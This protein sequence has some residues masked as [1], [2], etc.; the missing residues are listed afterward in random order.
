MK[1]LWSPWRMKFVQSQEANANC[2]FCRVQA[3]TNDL[4]NLIVF[5]GPRAF[6]ILNRYPYTSGHLLV[7][8]NSHQPSIE[9]LDIEIRSEMMELATVCMRVIRK[10]YQPEAFNLGANIGEAAGAGIAGHVH[11]HVVPRWGGDTNFMSALA[12]TRVLPEELS[13]T[14]HRIC[15]AWINR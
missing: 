5:R 11:L 7:V 9:D 8:A 3:Q 10:V 12:E 2:V 13:E 14:Y 6:V 4:E 1:R 15:A